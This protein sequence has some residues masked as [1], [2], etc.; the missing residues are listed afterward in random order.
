MERYMEEIIEL[1]KGIKLQLILIYLVNFIILT[2]LFI[3]K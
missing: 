2:R 3:K 1:L